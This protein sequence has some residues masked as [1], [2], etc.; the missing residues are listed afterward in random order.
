M[1]LVLSRAAFGGCE[2]DG[3]RWIDSGIPEE[4][5]IRFMPPYPESEAVATDLDIHTGFSDGFPI[6]PTPVVGPEIELAAWPRVRGGVTRV[7][8]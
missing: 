7:E 6:P 5:V 4:L 3:S 8:Y 1:M 2:R